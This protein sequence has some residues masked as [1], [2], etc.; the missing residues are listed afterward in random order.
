MFLES[1]IVFIISFSIL[2]GILF[3]IEKE[4]NKK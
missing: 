4:K 3:Y 2:G 1:L